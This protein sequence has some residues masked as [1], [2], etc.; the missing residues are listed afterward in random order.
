MEE[1]L[2]VKAEISVPEYTVTEL[3]L[4]MRR[5][6]EKEYAQVFV[7]G[8]ISGYKIANSGHAYFNLKDEQNLI[9]CVCWNAALRKMQFAL[10]D[11]MS[12]IVKGTVTIYGGQ[13]K[14][15]INVTSIRLLGEGR[16]MQMFQELKVR[17][18]KEGLF[19]QSYK[20]S[21]PSWPAVIAVVTSP[22]GAVFWD[23]IHRIRDRFPTTVLL[24]PVAV[25]GASSADEIVK[26]ISFLNDL[27]YMQDILPDVIIVA[28]GGGSIEDLWSFNE[29]KVVRSVFNSKIPIISAIGHETDFTLTDFVADLRAPTPTAAAEFVAPVMAEFKNR[30]TSFG[31][32]LSSLYTAYFKQKI[33]LLN[34]YSVSDYSLIGL[35]RNKEQR[36]DDLD[37][38]MRSYNWRFYSDHLLR[39]KLKHEAIISIINIKKLLL[40]NLENILSR[41]AS[42]YLEQCSKNL[43]LSFVQMQKLDVGRVLRRGFALVKSKNKVLISAKNVE[44]GEL[45]TLEFYDGNVQAQVKGP[46]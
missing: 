12:V 1:D 8:E 46:C 19:D 34:A 6:I 42:Q 29:E 43:N 30:L 15:Q 23:V 36:F 13:S 3:T 39:H 22:Q 14:Y 45:V 41:A 25:Q 38:K 28:R 32:R 16:L 18:S 7:I 35:L 24:Y 5:T 2:L 31:T 44:S 20:K 26:A 40:K 33:S 27:T 21:I 37:A 10:E 17:L 9:G 4:L 11:G